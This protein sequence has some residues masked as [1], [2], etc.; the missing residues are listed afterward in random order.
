M[1]QTYYFNIA[2]D[3][4]RLSIEEQKELEDYCA[5][6]AGM[7]A[8]KVEGMGLHFLIGIGEC[9]TKF[10]KEELDKMP[11]CRRNVNGSYSKIYPY[12]E[13][14]DFFDKLKE[15]FKDCPEYLDELEEEMRWYEEDAT[16]EDIGECGENLSRF[17]CCVYGND[18]IDDWLNM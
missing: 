8:Q 16:D 11:R 6:L 17:L 9:I 2:Y 13:T 12:L 14:L 1:A 4:E 5:E 10:T 18:N 3:E 7:L 15:S